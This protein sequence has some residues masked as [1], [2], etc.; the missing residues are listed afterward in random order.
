MA[1]K[2][3]LLLSTFLFC[4]SWNSNAQNKSEN[5]FA[6]AEEEH[7]AIQRK[8]MK[9]KGKK[10]FRAAFNKSM[11]DKVKQYEKRQKKNA[12]DEKKKALAMLKPQYSDPSYFGHKKK[13]KKRPPGKRKFC[14]ECGIT[15]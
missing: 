2:K 12:R 9:K 11:D 7:S 3:A 10:S 6:P 4:V 15:H 14:Q 13:P 8:T 5:S 1:F